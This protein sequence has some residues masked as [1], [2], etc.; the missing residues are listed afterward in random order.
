MP[1]R[2]LQRKLSPHKACSCYFYFGICHLQE[3]KE[4]SPKSLKN[5]SAIT[6]SNL[7]ELVFNQY[8]LLQKEYRLSPTF[9]P[10]PHSPSLSWDLNWQPFLHEPVSVRS[11]SLPP[12]GLPVT[13]LLYQKGHLVKAKEPWEH[14]L[15]VW[16][17]NWSIRVTCCLPSYTNL[18]QDTTET[19]RHE[20]L[21]YSD[22]YFCESH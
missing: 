3:A 15:F 14:S 2:V 12:L 19:Q 11:S 4:Y 9:T 10:W 20:C 5:G 6:H 17:D 8:H 22:E 13:L 16:L 7:F 18:C 21:V 1:Q